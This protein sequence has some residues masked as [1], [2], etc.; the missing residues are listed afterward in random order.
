MVALFG[1]KK[2]DDKPA[3]TAVKSVVEKKP[4]KSTDITKSEKKETAISTPKSTSSIK[5]TTPQAYRVLIKPL[6]TEKVAEMN[7]VGKY[8]FMID[9]SMNKVEVKKAIRS[10]YNVDPI[11]VNIANFRGKQVRFGRVQGKRKNWKKAVVTLKAGDSIEVY[12]GI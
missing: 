10:I 9:P 2:K 3:E 6:V 12:E 1:K 4:V 11:K 7:V 5:G 8:A